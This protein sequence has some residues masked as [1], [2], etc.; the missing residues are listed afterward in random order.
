MYSM[1]SFLYGETYTINRFYKKYSFWGNKKAYKNPLK[2]QKHIKSFYK[3]I[4]LDRRHSPLMDLVGNS[5][6]NLSFHYC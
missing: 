2:S 3:F 5:K 1:T 4:K 6:V